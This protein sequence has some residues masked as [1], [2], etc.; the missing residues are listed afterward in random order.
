[1]S[2]VEARAFFLK[3]ESYCNFDLPPYFEFDALL[4]KLSG[5]L[6]GKNLGTMLS[7]NP[8]DYD[9]LNHTILN[10]KDGRFAWRP[11][12]LTH[13]ALYVSLV[14]HLTE[15]ANW[16]LLQKRLVFFAKNPQIQCLSLPVE[17][18]STQQDKAEQV[19]Q[20][21]QEVEQRSIELSLE[22][23][24]LAHTDITDCYGSIYTHSVPWALHKRS[25]MKRTE[26]RGNPA[27]LGNV[28]DHHL[29]DL[30]QGQTNGIPQGSV[31]MDFLAEIVLGY[32][33]FILSTKLKKCQIDDYKILR[34]RDDYRI[35]A[36]HPTHCE[37]IIKAISETMY[38]LGMKLQPSKTGI[39]SEVIR[40]SIKADKIDWI[41][42][43]QFEKDLQKHLV[44]IHDLSR[45]HP[46][47]GS[48][49]RALHEFH[50][51]LLRHKDNIPNVRPQIS[52]VVDIALNSPK[53][54]ATIAAIISK[55]VC[56]IKD[57]SE[58][59]EILFKIKKRFDRVPNT[60][61]LQVWLQRISCHHEK[62]IEYPEA[63]CKLVEGRTVQLWN[64]DWISSKK[65]KSALSP[66]KIFNKKIFNELK[67]IIQSEEVQ[68]FESH[69]L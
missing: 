38:F 3:G 10:N 62:G 7:G 13:P 25:V 27:F 30:N 26:N 34:Y 69:S 8:R 32:A 21:W 58:R 36:N 51:R 9:Q 16:D 50:R 67:P 14:H 44:L 18:Q 40:H 59:S 61:H 35:F 33:D 23:E 4:A 43:K 54:Y 56:S 45:K 55:L 41:G 39:T 5:I 12:Q 2:D 47:S 17:S 31:L 15:P 65:I 64:S 22:Y 29:Q 53:V 66:T 42:R 46:N 49:M 11:L 63:L 48:T 60:G 19:L 28:I 6:A 1:M 24:Y 68:L 52:L 20:W 57:V 37:E